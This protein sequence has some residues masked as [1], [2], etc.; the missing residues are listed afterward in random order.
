VLLASQAVGGE[1]TSDSR[2]SATAV[3]LIHNFSLV[4]DDIQDHSEL[5]RHRPTVWRLWGMP[6]AI[7]VGDALFALAQVVLAEPGTALAAQLTAELSRTA[8][9]LAEGQFLDLD[10]QAGLTKATLDAYED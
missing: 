7:N 8:L 4:H 3:E 6:Q 9:A 1:I 5:R 10:L 2:N